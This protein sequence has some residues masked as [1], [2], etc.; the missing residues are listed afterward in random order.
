MYASN[1]NVAR[2]VPWGPSTEEET[3]AYINYAISCQYQLPRVDYE[4]GVILK[5]QNILIGGCGLHVSNSS[6]RE[7][8]IGYVINPLFIG[9]GY[10]TETAR[11]LLTFGFSEL[12]LHR[13]FATCHTA[14]LVSAHI[15]EKIGMQREGCLRE[16]T[17]KHNQWSSSFLYSILEYE[18]IFSD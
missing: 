12:K 3:K 11:A 1:P 4:L 2:F 18:I 14:N 9:E 16:H 8:W 6:N 7:G 5:T 17:L 15:L 10:A 13:I